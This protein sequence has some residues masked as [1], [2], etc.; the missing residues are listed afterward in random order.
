MTCFMENGACIYTMPDGS[1]L[2]ISKLI[3]SILFYQGLRNAAVTKGRRG[4]E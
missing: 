2:L 3:C 4:Q 1:H